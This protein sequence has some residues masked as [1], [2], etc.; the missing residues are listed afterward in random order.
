VNVS[1]PFIMRPVA[2]LLLSLGLF[3]AGVVAY[4]NLPVASLPN[5]DIPAIVIF[6]NRPGADPATMANSV[7]APLER[8]LADIG[9]ITEVNSIN[10]AGNSLVVAVFDFDRDI[11]GAAHD[12]QSAINAAQADLPSDF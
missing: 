5:L 1:T 6:A 7:A 2:T 12:V 4:L 3:V 8:R 9:G 10:S 11:D